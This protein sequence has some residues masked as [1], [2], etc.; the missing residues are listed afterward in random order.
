[1]Q[2]TGIN[3]FFKTETIFFAWAQSVHLL[4]KQKEKQQN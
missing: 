2:V 3:E 4:F 1:M